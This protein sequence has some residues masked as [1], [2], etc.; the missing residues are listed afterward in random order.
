MT[1]TFRP[2]PSA[3][4]PPSVTLRRVLSTRFLQLWLLVVAIALSIHLGSYPLYDADEG[5]NGEVGREMAATNDYVMPRLDGMP[6]L[7]KPIVYFAAEAA[8]MEIL[9][10]TELAAR[11]PALLFTFLTAALVMWFAR[12]VWGSEEALVA[13]IAFLSMP[14]V[15]AFSRTVIFD[16]AL[17][18]F[19]VLAIMAF[20][21][22]VEEAA[23]IPSV[24]EGS[25]R[26]EGA[27]NDI[28]GAARPAK[29]FASLGM[30]K[31]WTILAWAAIG[32]GVLT[33]GP[34]ALA[35]PLI[36]AIPYAIRRKAFRA[37]W[38]WWGLAVFAVV[39]AP[40]VWAISLAVPDFLQ[41]VLVTET[42]QRLATKAL[43]RTGAPWYFVPYLIG[44]ALPWSIVAFFAWRRKL[45][46]N[47]M[48][49]IA[50]WILVPFLFFSLSQSKRPQYIVP[51]MPAIALA[52]AHFWRDDR[53]ATAVRFAAIAVL[54]LGIALVAAP[55][56]V[57]HRAKIDPVIAAGVDA[58]ALPM[59]IAALA[60]AVAAIA[61]AKRRDIALAALSLPVIA[62]PLTAN[63]LLQSIGVLRSEK[64][65]VSQMK[66]YLTPETQVIGI[67]SY[68]GSMSFYLGR[69]IVVATPK[70]EEFTS[71][72]IIRH[73]ARFA[74]DPQSSLRRP[75]WL[76]RN[77]DSCC[78]PRIYIIRSKD[79]DGRAA[80]AVRGIRRIA[81]D[82]HFAAYGPWRGR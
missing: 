42:A 35:L 68:T 80:L 34:V 79:A 52:V 5:R 71:N 55:A 45:R 67:E 53:R 8:A 33:K 31:R 18:F 17:S 39:I 47:P 59:G 48:F 27:E 25:G 14:L 26:A 62:I 50:L 37:L 44:G 21:F 72:Y 78:A 61:F 77:L 22:A 41:Y 10:P 36:V 69:E 23:V 51:L 30:T 54:I 13:A 16:S 56:I 75:E 2:P 74:D 49:F 7:D 4:R 58:S 32:F 20:Y 28:L 38:S 65:L 24:S 15:L 82:G 6:Y 63:P 81:S 43:K 3:F 9:G 29:S 70:G 40:W 19:I 11:L 1:P 12:R 76:Q 66:P 46:D 73:Y 64:A 60:G 57:H